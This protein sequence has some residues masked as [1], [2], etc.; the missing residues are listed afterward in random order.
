[1]NQTRFL[2]LL[3]K[4]EVLKLENKSLYR[5][6]RLEFSELNSY[7][8]ILQQQIYYKNRFQYINLIKRCLD[9]EI[10]CYRLQWDFF[11][12][13]Q[14]DMKATD[15]DKLIKTVSKYEIDSEMNFDIDSKIENFSSLLDDQ[16]VPICDF[17]D[18]GLS[19]ENFYRELQQIYSEML[20]D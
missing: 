13:Y 11:E 2:E 20:Q 14:N 10:N 5:V 4:E 1:M 19:E 16:L 18:D 7:I 12:M 15:I 17:L 9:G 3:H 8:M 6:N